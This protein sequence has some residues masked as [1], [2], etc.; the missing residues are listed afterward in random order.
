[1]FPHS[2]INSDERTSPERREPAGLCGDGLLATKLYA[3][4]IGAG[5]VARPRLVAGLD[6]S[7]DRR[8]ASARLGSVPSRSP[9]AP[10]LPRPGHPIR[11]SAAAEAATDPWSTRRDQG[12]RDSQAILSAR[13]EPAVL[14]VRMAAVTAPASWARSV[15]RFTAEEAAALLD[16]VVRI[17]SQPRSFV[18]LGNRD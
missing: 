4:Q 2:R 7:R 1:M 17:A 8:A 18:G 15:I 11:S 13:A 3:T 9:A 14:R 10:A 12:C 5:F 16:R 6:V